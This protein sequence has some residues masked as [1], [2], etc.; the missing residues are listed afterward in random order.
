MEIGDVLWFTDLDH[1]GD[2]IRVTLVEFE[3]K[4]AWVEPLFPG[5]TLWDRAFVSLEAL[6][7]EM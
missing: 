4:G 7:T 5:D 1:D 2:R 3:N 6:S